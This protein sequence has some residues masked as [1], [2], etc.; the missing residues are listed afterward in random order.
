MYKIKFVK[1]ITKELILDNLSQEEIMSKYLGFKVNPSKVFC[2]PLREDNHPTCRFYYTD[3][4]IL[5]FHDF[6]GAFHGDCFSVVMKKYNTDF[7]NA[8]KIIAN[9]FN[10]ANNNI[11]K[12]AHITPY[13]KPFKMNEPKKISV[14]VRMW[15]DDDLEYWHKGYRI[16]KETLSFYH[17]YPISFAWVGDKIVYTYKKSDPAYA[18][19]FGINE[20]KIYFPKR[21]DYRFLGNS[22]TIQGFNQLPEKGQLLIITKSLKDVMTLREAGYHAISFQSEAY[23]PKDYDIV[24]L[25]LRF[26]SIYTLYD[27]D[28]TGVRTANKIRKTY[29]IEPIFINKMRTLCKDASDFAFLYGIFDLKDYIDGLISDRNSKI[30]HPRTAF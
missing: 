20:Y 18:Y 2:S 30:Y 13:A 21:K 23:F 29:G 27:F 28:L 5:M 6:S 7:H 26:N 14:Q 16:K 8:C 4:N 1:P 17:V 24:P 12:I 25:K 3:S 9:D 10:I 11:E 19:R 22:R 15:N